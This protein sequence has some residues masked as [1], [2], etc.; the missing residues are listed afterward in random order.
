VIRE[1]QSKSFKR[2]QIW[3]IVRVN[4]IPTGHV[5]TSLNP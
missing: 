4:M 1:L 5:V 3:T 2:L